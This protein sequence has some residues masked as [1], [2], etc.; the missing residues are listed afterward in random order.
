MS[1][2][3]NADVTVSRVSSIDEDT[4]EVVFKAKSNTGLGYTMEVT[5]F[6]DPNDVSTR[7]AVKT[8]DLAL[9]E[10]YEVMHEIAE[11]I[12]AK[13]SAPNTKGGAK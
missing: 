6:Q 2:D 10:V 4:V 11:R 5:V 13:E 7:E 9:A 1:K 3:S 12:R 8:M